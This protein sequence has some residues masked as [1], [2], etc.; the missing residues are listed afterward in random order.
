MGYTGY[1]IDGRRH[2][3]DLKLLGLFEVIGRLWPATGDK[4]EKIR[5]HL[6][7]LPVR[8]EGQRDVGCKAS[9][10][11]IGKHP[12]CQ[13]RLLT[14]SPLRDTK[15]MLR[16]PLYC[17]YRYRDQGN[18]PHDGG[19]RRPSSRTVRYVVLWLAGLH[20]GNWDRRELRCWSQ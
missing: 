5:F 18:Q 4:D 8:M 11:S 9:E 12:F 10:R 19:A 7:P 17:T 20:G 3:G 2:S 6:S 1:R 15:A 13:A 16:T 14:C